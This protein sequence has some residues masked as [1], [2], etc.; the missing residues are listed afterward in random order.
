MSEDMRAE[1]QHWQARTD[2][3][4]VALERVREDR[5]EARNKALLL[6]TTNQMLMDEVK[7]LRS[8]IERI[9]VA[10]SQGQEL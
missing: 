2:E 10:M 6:E 7:Q 8:M 3:M 4:Q 1:L 9:Q 5:D